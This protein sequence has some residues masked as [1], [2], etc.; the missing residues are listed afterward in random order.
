MQEVTLGVSQSAPEHLWLSHNLQETAFG[1]RHKLFHS[2]QQSAIGCLK[3]CSS[4]SLVASQSA[5]VLLVI[6]QSAL[7][8]HCGSF[9]QLSDQHQAH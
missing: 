5:T 1:G 7:E 8:G 6:S 9:Q 4:V 3:I 2:Q